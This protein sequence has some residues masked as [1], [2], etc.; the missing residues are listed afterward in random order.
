M[1]PDVKKADLEWYICI[2]IEGVC[3]VCGMNRQL[4]AHH[5]VPRSHKA[6]RHAVENGVLL[7]AE[8]HRGKDSA[9][10][11]PLWFMAWLKEN[12]PWQAKWVEENRHKLA[13]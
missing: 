1:R 10:N 8:H 13:V 5:I 3:A 9:H 12:R 4:E 11:A 2:H 7:C 6:T